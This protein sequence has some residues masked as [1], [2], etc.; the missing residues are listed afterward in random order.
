MS[1]A[2]AMF[3][4]S[5]IMPRLMGPERTL[6]SMDR[7]KCHFFA[8]CGDAEKKASRLR[9]NRSRVRGTRQ[10]TGDVLGRPFPL[11]LTVRLSERSDDVTLS[12][13]FARK[14]YTGCT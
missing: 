1:P 6:Q 11:E 2:L 12:R 10:Q 8:E 14:Q 5:P 3:Q 9:G 7:P 4:P 13:C